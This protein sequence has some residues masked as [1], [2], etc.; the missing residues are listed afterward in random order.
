VI[1]DGEQTK[2][3]FATYHLT[4][5]GNLAPDGVVIDCI[6]VDVDRM[7]PNFEPT[8]RQSMVSLLGNLAWGPETGFRDMCHREISSTT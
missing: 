4:G 6:S 7:Q 8:R 3:T 1:T 5:V 2:P